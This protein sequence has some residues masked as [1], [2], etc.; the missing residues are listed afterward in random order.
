MLAEQVTM[1]PM[2]AAA[3]DSDRGEGPVRRQPKI[4]VWGN[5]ESRRG[6]PPFCFLMRFTF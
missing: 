2:L 1:G 6:R 4:G 3:K 5:P